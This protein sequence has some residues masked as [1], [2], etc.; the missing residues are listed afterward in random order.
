MTR[1]SCAA[2]GE[3]SVLSS[4]TV[5]YRAVA[6]RLRLYWLWSGAERVLHRCT[7]TQQ[8]EESELS[9]GEFRARWRPVSALLLFQTEAV[10][11]RLTP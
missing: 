2:A 5:Q 3:R 7:A 6:C 11:S 4:F 1:V 9:L 10:L 8:S